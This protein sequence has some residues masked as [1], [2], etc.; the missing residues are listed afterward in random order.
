MKPV[1]LFIFF[2]VLFFTG[3]ASVDKK[4]VRLTIT[5]TDSIALADQT[6]VYLDYGTTPAFISLEDSRKQFNQANQVP[7]IFSF[8]SDGVPCLINGYG[9]FNNSVSMGIGIR[10]DSAGDFN[11]T[12]NIIS[13]LDPTSIV[14]LEDRQLGTFF[15]LRQG[16]YSFHA[17]SGG[18]NYNRFALH[19]SYPPAINPVD[20]GC[21]NL[22]G[23][24]AVMEDSTIN[25]SS[26]LLYDSTGTLVGN[27]VD[28]TGPFTYSGLAEGKYALVFNYGLYS[29]TKMVPVKG[30][31][32]SVAF[33]VSVDNPGV[34]QP[35]QFFANVTN[36]TQ[37][38]WDFSDG[39]SVTGIANPVVTF[40]ESGTIVAVLTAYNT[41]G[42][43]D[44]T[45]VTFTVGTPSGISSVKAVAPHIY[46]NNN[47]VVIETNGAA[48]STLYTIN[49]MLGQSVAS[50]S[51]ETA[52]YRVSMG[53][54]PDGVYVASVSVSGH[55]YS[56]KLYLHR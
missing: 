9:P 8:T 10:V 53:S 28:V 29:A 37:Y 50:G 18:F 3:Y 30:H 11:I 1:S 5:G 49:N 26:T 45:T 42:C 52:E 19:I 46:A 21:D 39:T 38:Q 27:M 7:Q 56:Q 23:G 22:N 33:T 32:I 48:G 44:S 41:Y 15:D 24:I 20:A 36:A 54:L 16:S 31:H 6:I 14:R 34:G 17:D 25:W 51:F 13:Q 55:H 35:V 43:L 47:Y 12:A 4:E 2:S 40:Y